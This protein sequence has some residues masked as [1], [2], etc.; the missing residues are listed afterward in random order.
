MPLLLAYTQF[1]ESVVFWVKLVLGII[2]ILAGVYKILK[3]APNVPQTIAGQTGFALITAVVNSQPAIPTGL[4]MI[5]LGML[6]L[7]VDADAIAKIIYGG[8]NGGGGE[9]PTTTPSPT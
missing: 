2:L 4:L 6:L 1:E 7:G 5:G 9:T 3:E 8:D